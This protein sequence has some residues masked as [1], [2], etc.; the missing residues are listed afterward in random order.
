MVQIREACE[1]C[2]GSGTQRVQAG[3]GHVRWARRVAC[4][5]CQGS[6]RRTR[7][8]TLDELRALLARSAG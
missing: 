7:W 8:I 1:A 6:G 3:T 4:E 5:T 2:E